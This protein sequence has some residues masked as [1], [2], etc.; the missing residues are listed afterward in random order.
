MCVC[1]G[2]GGHFLSGLGLIPCLCEVIYLF[3]YSACMTLILC[4]HCWSVFS[5]LFQFLCVSGLEEEEEEGGVLCLRLWASC[6]QIL[7]FLFFFFFC[8]RCLLIC[9]SSPALFMCVCV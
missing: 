8:S 1:G 5:C 9:F 3:K 2:D 4:A 6:L 7:L